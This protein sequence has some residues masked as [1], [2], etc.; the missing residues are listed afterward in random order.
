[1]EEKRNKQEI[2][3]KE[4]QVNRELKDQELEQVVGGAAQR[5]W[6]PTRK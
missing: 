4:V 5:P 6:K 1:M 2:K 3:D